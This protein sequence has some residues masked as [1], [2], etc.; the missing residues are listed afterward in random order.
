VCD[1]TWAQL[2][3]GGEDAVI[4]DEVLVGAGDE[5]GE[6]LEE[7]GGLEVEVGSAV[8]PRRLD[9]EDEAAAVLFESSVGKGWA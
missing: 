8:I 1:D 7:L 6:A 5:G 9:G 3:V 2:G 4:E